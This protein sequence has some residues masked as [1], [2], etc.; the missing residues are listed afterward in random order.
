M[1]NLVTTFHALEKNMYFLFICGVLCVSIRLNSLI[2]LFRSSLFLLIF[3][4]LFYLLLWEVWSIFFKWCTFNY[5]ILSC[6]IFLHIFWNCYW[7]NT[8]LET[9]LS[10][11]WIE[12]FVIIKSISV[13][14]NGFYLK[15]YFVW[16]YMAI[17][18][19]FWLVFVCIPFLS[20]YFESFHVPIFK[21]LTSASD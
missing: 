11:W 6:K 8:N 16:C 7:R 17:S 18:T 13:S 9:V 3:S 2:A 12:P 10:S 19:F 15:F 21:T 4:C 1:S 14:S 5:F 20:F